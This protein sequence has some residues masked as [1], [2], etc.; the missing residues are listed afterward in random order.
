MW[1][2]LTH[3]ASGVLERPVPSWLAPHARNV[4]FSV[5]IASLVADIFKDFKGARNSADA[6]GAGDTGDGDGVSAFTAAA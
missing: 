3:S 6:A 4:P 5:D 1:L 2:A